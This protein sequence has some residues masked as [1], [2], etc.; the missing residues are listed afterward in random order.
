M[1]D[2]VLIAGSPNLP[3]RSAAVL[4]RLENALRD[5]GPSIASIAVRN[6]PADALLCGDDRHPAVRG[7]IDLIAS[8]HAVAVATPVYKAAYSGALKAFVDL[9]PLDVLEGKT[10]LPIATGG[11]PVNR[12]ALEYAVRPLLSAIGARHV[13]GSIYVPDA[14]LFRAPSGG[15]VLAESEEGRLRAAAVDLIAA[16]R[17]VREKELLLAA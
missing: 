6:L 11:S 17:P 14:N 12:L 16:V 4:E 7:A 15:F 8:A 3:S 5:E 13:L 2:I 10:V 9:L 1:P